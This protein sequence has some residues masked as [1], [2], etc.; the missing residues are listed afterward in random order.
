[1]GGCELHEGIKE[2]VDRLRNDVAELYAKTAN[3]E[4]RL[5]RLDERDKH[6]EDIMDRIEKS[7]EMGNARTEGLIS[8]LSDQIANLKTSVE[9]LKTAPAK[10]TAARVD[11]LVTTFF[12]YLVTAGAGGALIYG[13]AKLIGG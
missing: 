10:K 3:H 11:D 4:E 9:D 2:Q 13:I 1:M 7:I 8:A 5:G 6:R 12:K